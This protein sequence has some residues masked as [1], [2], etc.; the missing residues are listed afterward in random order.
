MGNLKELFMRNLVKFLGI[1]AFVAM[2]GVLMTA[3]PPEEKAGEEAKG[4]I[5][6]KSLDTKGPY[7]VNGASTVLTAVYEGDDANV[8]FWWFKDEVGLDIEAEVNANP[9]SDKILDSTTNAT[10]KDGDGNIINTYSASTPGSYIVAVASYDPTVT[11]YVI[12]KGKS[13]PFA[14]AAAGQDDPTVFYGT[15]KMTGSANNNWKPDST[16][17]VTDETIVIDY[18]NFKLDSTFE[19]YATKEEYVAVKISAATAATYDYTV[20]KKEHVYWTISHWE[21]RN[22]PAGYKLSYELT[23]KV[24][25][26]KGYENYA[27]FVILVT[28]DNIVTM[29]RTQSNGTTIIGRKYV[30]QP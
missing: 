29:Q 20:G 10:T 25:S 28:T 24:T 5:S 3:C 16:A 30:K 1:I 11:T 23:T 17:P 19:G 27:S 18:L 7:I 14:V 13:K 2:M 26:N 22:A 4:E 9:A 12:G 15:W 21:K 8:N 6:I